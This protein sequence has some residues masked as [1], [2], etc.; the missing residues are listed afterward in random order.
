MLVKFHQVEQVEE[1]EES[2]M[3]RRLYSSIDSQ[4]MNEVCS[5]N[6]SSCSLS[7]HQGVDVSFG[8]FEKDTRGIGSKLL[9]KMEF[10]GKCLGIND[11]GMINP[12]QVEEIHHYVRSGYGKGEIG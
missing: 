9:T 3:Q 7:S 4:T 8:E 2:T 11:Q 1:I 12:M 6:D 5:V 10:D